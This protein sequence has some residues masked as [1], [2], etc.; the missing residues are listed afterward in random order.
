MIGQT[1]LQITHRNAS[2]TAVTTLTLPLEKRIHS[3]QRVTLDNGS[4]AGLFLERGHIL[5]NGDLIGTDDGVIVEIK[6]A[7]EAVSTIQ[8]K[9]ALLLS[10][11]C[12]HLGNRHVPV[13]ISPDSVSYQHDH[14]L[15]EMVRGLGAEPTIAMAP[16]EP[17]AGAYDSHTHHN[18]SAT[19]QNHH[20]HDH[21]DK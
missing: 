6:A 4:E 9:D 8:T 11:L 1:M 18:H 17:E 21:N 2:G 14:V 15:D 12:Y 19:D 16:F 13:Q 7:P 20:H 3:R 5:R 10:R